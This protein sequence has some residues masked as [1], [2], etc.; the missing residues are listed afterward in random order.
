ML[1]FDKYLCMNH[2][3]QLNGIK[4]ECFFFIIKTQLKCPERNC[5]KKTTGLKKFFLNVND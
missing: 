2:L 5:D 4:D 1:C 3:G